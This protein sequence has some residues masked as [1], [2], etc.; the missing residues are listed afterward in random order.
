ME[1]LKQS[2]FQQCG[3]VYRSP[4]GSYNP[5]GISS[6]R[7]V[8]YVLSSQKTVNLSLDIRRTRALTRIT[9]TCSSHRSEMC[10]NFE[11]VIQKMGLGSRSA[12]KIL[13]ISITIDKTLR[14]LE[15]SSKNGTSPS[16]STL[17]VSSLLHETSKLSARSST[18]SSSHESKPRL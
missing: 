5:G 12:Q 17:I 14:S 16:L 3:S 9:R 13:L 10:L 7:S 11:I 18:E 4:G 8:G 1:D 6:C 15:S 2:K